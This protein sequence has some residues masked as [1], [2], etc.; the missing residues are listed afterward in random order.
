M[1]SFSSEEIFQ[2]KSKKEEGSKA[3]LNISKSVIK[4]I[5]TIYITILHTPINNKFKM[6]EKLSELQLLE[7]KEAFTTFDKVYYDR[8]KYT[9]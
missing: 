2:L 4:N 5:Y 6:A 3:I 9:Y 8:Y 7:F 1:C